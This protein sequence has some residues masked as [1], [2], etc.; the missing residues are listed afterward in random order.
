[1]IWHSYHGAGAGCRPG[2]RRTCTGRRSM[3]AAPWRRN[4]VLALALLSLTGAR[5]AAGAE[6]WSATSGDVQVRCRL[7]VGGSFDAVTTALSGTLA[8][9]APDGADYA[10]VLRVDLATLDSGIGLRNS[11]LRD[12]YLEVERGPEFREAVLS[13]IVLDDPLPAGAGRHETGV[14][15]NAL[16]ARGAAP[17]RGRS[18]AAPSRRADAGRSDVSPSAWKR[19]TSRRHATWASVSGTP[20]RSLSHSTRH[21]HRC[22]VGRRAMNCSGERNAV[23]CTESRWAATRIAL[24]L[25]RRCWRHGA[26]VRRSPNRS[27][28]SKQYRTL[29]RLSLLGVGRRPADAVRTVAVA[30]GDL[31]V[32]APGRRR[33][34]GAAGRRRG[35]LPLRR[36]SG[37][38]TRCSS[39]STSGPRI[40]ASTC[41]AA[42]WPTAISS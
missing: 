33:G 21:A 12:N 2:G 35:R 7:T 31:D 4:F 36:C 29:H 32:R 26:P 19:S 37:T 39:A 23:T 34:S 38:R 13:S 18:G 42:P 16:P 25:P 15:G 17:D 6:S 8:R 30:G 27:F 20:W 10:G 22:A 28:L 40:W 3:N 5:S 9:A 14:L 24:A 41:L 1:M 11:H